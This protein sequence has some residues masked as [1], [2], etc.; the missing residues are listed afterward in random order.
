MGD[1]APQYDDSGRELWWAAIDESNTDP[2]DSASPD[3][4]AH[5]AAATETPNLISSRVQ[6]GVHR[7]TID[8]DH[9][10]RL[11]E[12]SPGKFHL[13]IE[14]DVKEPDYFNMLDAMA[15]AGVVEPGYADA[16]RDQG[17]S[18][19]RMRPEEKRRKQHDI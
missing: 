4:I 9:P 6:K 12:T 13:F 10:C 11:R 17:A 19:V 16:C 15:I 2:D 5:P 14:V 18:F 1:A 7:P 3:R 8:I